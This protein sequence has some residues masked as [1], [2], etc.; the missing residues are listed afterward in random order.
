MTGI[1]AESPG[2]TARRLLRAARTAAL[3]SHM[4]ADHWPHASLVLLAT[5]PDATP[6][7]LLSALAEHTRNLGADQRVA[8]LVDGTAELAE[9]LTGPR[10]SV[11]GRASRSD[12]PAD[13][14]RYLRRHPAAAAYA[15]FGD[16]AFYRVA[17][18]RAH[19]V[20]GFGRI[21]WLTAAEVLY[22]GATPDCDLGALAAAE[23]EI[24]AHMNQ[25]HADAIQLYAT[26]LCGAPG[27]GWIMAGCDGEGCDLARDGRLLRLD[28]DEPAAT[29][30]DAR[31]QLVRL[32]KRARQRTA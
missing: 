27:R 24:I 21:H 17:V 16:F 10:L 19:L 30:D 2:L 31:R 8:L 20:A 18:E 13:R 9:P 23:A 6:L 12:D 5:A 1:A 3:A 28:F 11:L 4:A 29:P 26:V 15:D 14:T 32:A 25:D 7:L 22:G